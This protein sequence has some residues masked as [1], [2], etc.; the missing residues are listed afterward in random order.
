MQHLLSTYKDDGKTVSYC[1]RC[2]AEGSELP[3]DCP[4]NAISQ[5][6]KNQ[7]QLR[8]LDYRSGQW[9]KIGG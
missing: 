9:L 2:S 1:K 6:E 4:G 5:D 7:V 3:T 8:R